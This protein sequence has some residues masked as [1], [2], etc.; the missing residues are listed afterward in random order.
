MKLGTVVGQSS[1]QSPLLMDPRSICCQGQVVKFSGTGRFE[2][3]GMTMRNIELQLKFSLL[4][5]QARSKPGDQAH[6]KG[7][8]QGIQGPANSRVK[9]G[10]SG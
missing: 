6:D 9:T 8:G 7:Q 4:C 3:K 10:I 5:K 2:P 1:M